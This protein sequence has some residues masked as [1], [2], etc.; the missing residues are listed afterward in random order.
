VAAEIITASADQMMF[1]SHK[2]PG[3]LVRIAK[4]MAAL[5]YP[6]GGVTALGIH[7]CVFPHPGCPA[8]ARRPCCCGCDGVDELCAW[9]RNGCPAAGTGQPCCTTNPLLG[10]VCE[11]NE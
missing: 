10:R 11:V 3:V 1:A 7:A 8:I 2:R 9:C 4:G 5:A 6:P